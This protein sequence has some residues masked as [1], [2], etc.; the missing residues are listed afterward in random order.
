[1]DLKRLLS[2]FAYKI[3]PK[4]E[5]GF[6]ARATDPSVPPLEASTREELQHM[7]QEKVFSALAAEFPQLRP[8]ADGRTRDLQFH[9][10]HTPGGETS[11]R[12]VDPNTPVSPASG[13]NDL[14][15]Y[16]LEKVL[17]FAGKRLTPE[18]SKA[19]AAQVGSAKIKVVI[20]GKTRF[21][22]NSGSQG[23]SF[24]T[25]QFSQTTSTTGFPAVL[26]PGSDSQIIGETIG[27]TPITPESSNAGKVF[28]LLLVF[29][30]LGGLA[31]FFFR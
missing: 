3:E 8:S 14:E 13:Q 11:I 24:G 10:E 1:M 22:L 18:L 9:I 29:L 31:Y 28:G 2:Q 30:I 4:P 25:P 15:N 7:I 6:I 16:L 20:N 19:L 21:D 5:G 27:N 17:N 23:L 12:S 26:T